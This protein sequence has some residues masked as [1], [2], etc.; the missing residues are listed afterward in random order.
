MCGGGRVRVWGV[1]LV[2]EVHVRHVSIVCVEGAVG[3]STKVKGS[4]E[5][6][7]AGGCRCEEVIISALDYSEYLNAKSSTKLAWIKGIK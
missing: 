1:G 4:L 7:G 5:S 3:F 2:R 6:L